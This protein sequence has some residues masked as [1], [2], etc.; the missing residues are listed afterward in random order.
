[1]AFRGQILTQRRQPIH[2]DGLMEAF[3]SIIAMASVMQTKEHLPQPVQCNLSTL[4]K[5]CVAKS[6]LT[7]GE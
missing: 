4:G 5:F 2:K 7:S 1:M 6:F 3:L